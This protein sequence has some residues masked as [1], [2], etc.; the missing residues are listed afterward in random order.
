MRCPFYDAESPKDHV[1]VVRDFALVMSS[2]N[3]MLRSN[4]DGQAGGDWCRR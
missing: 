3:R 1:D 4:Q 2:G